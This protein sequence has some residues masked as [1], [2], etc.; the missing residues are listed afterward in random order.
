[1]T[2]VEPEADLF[3]GRGPLGDLLGEASEPFVSPQ[4]NMAYEA[5]RRDL[6]QLLQERP[7]QWVG[8]HGSERVGFAATKEEMYRLCRDRGLEEDEFFVSCI[9]SEEEFIISLGLIG[10]FFLGPSL[11]PL[12][13]PGTDLCPSAESNQNPGR[14]K[15]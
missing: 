3:W 6:T 7:G 1:M 9:E 13:D 5:F 15:D 14:K 4:L 2:C 10:D 12:D 8:Y 11:N